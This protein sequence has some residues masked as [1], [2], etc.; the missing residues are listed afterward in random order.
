MPLVFTVSDIHSLI[1]L[2]FTELG[3]LVLNRLMQC[4]LIFAF[5]LVSWR[6]AP[7]FTCSSSK[8]FPVLHTASNHLHSISESTLQLNQ[9]RYLYLVSY[10][11]NWDYLNETDD[12]LRKRLATF[13]PRG[14]RI[15]TLVRSVSSV[16]SS[17]VPAVKNCPVLGYSLTACP[18]AI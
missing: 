6:T 17:T 3:R 10:R 15:A 14:T 4:K 2:V 9:T 13:Y 18:F 8:S 11:Q 5:P 1:E 12:F 7:N 16:P